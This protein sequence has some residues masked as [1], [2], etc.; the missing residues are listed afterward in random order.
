M[1]VFNDSSLINRLQECNSN[2]K[3]QP[4]GINAFL[5]NLKIVKNSN[6]GKAHTSSHNENKQL[7]QTV[8]YQDQPCQLQS[9]KNLEI[10]G[11]PVPPEML[12]KLKIIMKGLPVSSETAGAKS[13]PD[14]DSTSEQVSQI[15]RRQ[16][17]PPPAKP[18]LPLKSKLAKPEL[19]P[20]PKLA[21]PELPPKPKLAKPELPPKPKLAKPELPPK[22]KLAKP[23]LPPKPRLAKPELPP[24][25]RLAMRDVQ[26][27]PEM[28]KVN[29]PFF[30]P[31]SHKA[32]N[33]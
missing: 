18:E 3:K 13:I 7:S 24:K 17:P 14:K 29:K 23:E 20:K 27:N 22:P 15:K 31:T 32:V 21:K 33:H 9:D 4:K 10:K 1:V 8:K 26:Q 28:A 2:T 16:A 25:P 6:L 19:P 5:L 12:D 11:F 30:Y